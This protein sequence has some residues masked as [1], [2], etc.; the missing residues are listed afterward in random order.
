MITKHH[1]EITKNSK[2]KYHLKIAKT[3]LYLLLQYKTKSLS[4]NQCYIL[5]IN[6]SVALT[7]SLSAL[8]EN[9]PN[10]NS[11]NLWGK[12][13]FHLTRCFRS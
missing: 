7:I 12:G 1:K 8:G 4:E 5:N 13:C 10:S 9:N 11:T 2:V 3:P 6:I